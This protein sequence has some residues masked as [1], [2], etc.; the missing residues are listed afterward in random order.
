LPGDL[1]LPI[2]KV[3]DIEMYYEVTDFTNPWERTK[4]PSAGSW[5]HL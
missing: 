2:E 1:E 3:N 5:L 4:C